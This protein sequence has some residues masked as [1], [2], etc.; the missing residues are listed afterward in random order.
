M[1]FIKVPIL[2]GF[3]EIQNIYKLITPSKGMICGGY[4]RYCCSPLHK[5]VETNDLDIY[6]FDET[7]YNEIRA[8]LERIGFQIKTESVNAIT[9]KLHEDILYS[10]T[11]K[12]QLIKPM[13]E[14]KIVSFGTIEEILSNFDFSITRACVISETECL[15]DEDFL[16]DEKEKTLKLKNI[17]CPISSTLRC[18]KY[19]RKGYWL[20]P[21]ECIKL[22]EDWSNRDQA[23]KDN[24]FDLFRKSATFDETKPD[25][26]GL[27]KDEIEELERLLHID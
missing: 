23:Y 22:F 8:S 9:Y 19:A 4:A 18:M 25:N 7:S 16:K 17:H 6:P 14:G 27:T 12:L 11:P 10:A 3:T 15:V 24:L 20:P 5:P 26:S 13:K 1:S 2:R 21:S